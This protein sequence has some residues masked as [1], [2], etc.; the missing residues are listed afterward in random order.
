[1]TPRTIRDLM[2]RTRMKRNVRRTLATPTRIPIE[3]FAASLVGKLPWKTGDRGSLPPELLWP[4]TTP[5]EGL[6]TQVSKL[7]AP[8]HY[9]QQ[10]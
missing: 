7:V 4:S 10:S 1:M 3:A 5:T 8:T 2:K 6:L 9:V